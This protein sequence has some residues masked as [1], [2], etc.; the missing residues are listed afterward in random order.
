MRIAILGRKVGMTQVFDDKGAL[1]PITVVDTTGCIVSQVKTKDKD[2]YTALQLAVSD[3]KPQNVKKAVAGHFKKASSPAKSHIREIRLEDSDDVAP[4][5]AG[6]KV[7]ASIFQKGDVVDV[8][9]IS[10]GR[11][12]AGVMKRYNFRGKHATH[13]THEYFRHPGSAGTKTFPG[14][15]MKNKGMPGH[16]GDVKTTVQKMEIID[17]KAE[18]NLLFIKGGIPGSRD[19]KLLVRLAVKTGKHK[20][21]SLSASAPADK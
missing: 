5:Q 10:K 20:D 7:S 21:R 9:G 13:G 2:G 4:L 11:G 18:E 3:I 15:I 6:T 12:F 19:S 16:M 1:I 8:T 17:V 14:R